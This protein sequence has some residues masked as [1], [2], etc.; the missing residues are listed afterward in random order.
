MRLAGRNGFECRSLSRIARHVMMSPMEPPRMPD[1]TQD[2]KMPSRRTTRLKG[3]LHRSRPSSKPARGA[4]FE[5]DEALLRALKQLG[6]DVLSEPI[7]SRVLDALKTKVVDPINGQ[8]KKNKE[9]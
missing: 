7:P 4:D 5:T 3:D 8:Q 6:D 2:K 1:D 9:S